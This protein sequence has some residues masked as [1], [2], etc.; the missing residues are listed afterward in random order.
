MLIVVLIM[1]TQ[2][3]SGASKRIKVKKVKA[4]QKTA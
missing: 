1:S 2:V 3:G 4:P